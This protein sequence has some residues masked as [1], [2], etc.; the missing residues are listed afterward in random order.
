METTKPRDPL[1]QAWGD[2][3]KNKRDGKFTQVE[4]AARV[5]VEQATVSK[6]ENGLLIPS[7]RLQSRIVDALGIT[8]D[9]WFAIQQA[10]AA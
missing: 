8:A 7:P 10:G 2:A 4:L 3:I 9:D 6:W 5:G 1:A